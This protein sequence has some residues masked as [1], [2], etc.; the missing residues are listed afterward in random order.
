MGTD[1]TRVVWQRAMSET[2]RKVTLIN[3]DGTALEVVVAARKVLEANP[4]ALLMSPVTML[5]WM[6][7]ESYARRV[8]N[9]VFKVYAQGKVRT[10]DLSGKSNTGEFTQAN[11]GALG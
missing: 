7:H 9:A 2:R 4:T 8:E 3:G 5:A 10:G 6:G 1:G 11:L